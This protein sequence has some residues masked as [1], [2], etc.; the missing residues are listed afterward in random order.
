[1]RALMKDLIWVG[2][3]AAA[4]SGCIGI[5]IA[6]IFALNTLQPYEAVVA[7]PMILMTGMFLFFMS[8]GLLGVLKHR[9]RL[10][11]RG[12]PVPGERDDETEVMQTLH[13]RSLEMERRLESL[14]TILLSR[15]RNREHT[16]L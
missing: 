13:H 10:R 1:M 6:V 3:F 14:E 4:M 11:E 15:T 8:L 5:P 7:V 9:H 16:N 12:I 2:L